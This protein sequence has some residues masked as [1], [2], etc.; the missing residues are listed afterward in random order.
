L[1]RN[2]QF[3]DSIYSYTKKD[4][5]TIPVTENLFI[6]KSF[7]DTIFK[8]IRQSKLVEKKEYRYSDLGFY[9]FYKIIEHKTGSDFADFIDT[10]FYATLGAYRTSY[11]PLQKFNK[12]EIVPTENDQVFRRELIHGTVHDPGAAMLGGVCGHAGVFSTADDLAKIMQMFL[13]G[14]EYGD[15]KYFHKET[16]DLFSQAQFPG[17]DNRR[18][19]G[20]DKPQMDYTK[21]GPTCKCISAESYGHSGFTGT[22]V[23]ADPYQQIVYIFLSN[24]V[25]PD[26]DNNK[27]LKMNIR[28]EIQQAI[29]DAII[30]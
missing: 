14:G 6:R 28:T 30:N 7:T 26:Q 4:L 2:Y 1:A 5:F 18:A 13:W 12:N 15:E 9:Y 19:L 17:T 27:L 21:D 8:M 29:Y 10:T 24:R 20:F 16:I 3:R 25:H 23:W 22:M 11:L